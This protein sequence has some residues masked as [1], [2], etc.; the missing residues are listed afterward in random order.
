MEKEVEEEHRI[1]LNSEPA[2][3]GNGTDPSLEDPM[4][5]AQEEE[6]VKEEEKNEEDG[7]ESKEEDEEA[8]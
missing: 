3:P 4:S 7:E 2:H 1:D 6:E 5:N 8:K